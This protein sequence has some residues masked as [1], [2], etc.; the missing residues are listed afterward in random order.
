MLFGIT[1]ADKEKISN[2]AAVLEMFNKP[3]P[4][5]I[6]EVTLR[7]NLLTLRCDTV[8]SCLGLLVTHLQRAKLVG[9]QGK[10]QMIR[11]V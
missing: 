7:T 3:R 6:K 5:C 11:M 9:K 1:A 4:Y 2:C 10:G 8:V